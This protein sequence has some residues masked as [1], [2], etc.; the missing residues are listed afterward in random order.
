[1]KTI[2]VA[3]WGYPDSFDT[4]KSDRFNLMFFHKNIYAH[5]YQLSKKTG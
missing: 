3:Y 1:M 4:M 2:K 5:L